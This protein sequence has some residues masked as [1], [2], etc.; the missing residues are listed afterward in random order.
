MNYKDNLT[1]SFYETGDEVINTQGKLPLSQVICF[2]CFI[3][4]INYKTKL[5]G[6]SVTKQDLLGGK[7]KYCNPVRVPTASHEDKKQ[8]SSK[9]LSQRGRGR[10]G[11]GCD[12][13]RAPWGTVFPVGSPDDRW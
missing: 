3:S 12:S 10:R 1:G 4:F 2:I 8:K 11:E 7:S 5:T 13:R 6:L 9:S